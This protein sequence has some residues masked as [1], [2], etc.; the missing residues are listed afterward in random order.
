MRAEPVAL[1]ASRGAR[2]VRRRLTG[3]ISKFYEECQLLFRLESI[4]VFYPI[5]TFVALLE[6]GRRRKAVAGELG[7]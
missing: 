6:E 3:V 5:A 2:P 1:D 4:P 7:G